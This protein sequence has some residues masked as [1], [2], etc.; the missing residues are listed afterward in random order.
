MKN[1]ERQQEKKERKRI[2]DERESRKRD[3]LNVNLGGFPTGGYSPMI[4]SH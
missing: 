3:R 2:R 4:L 1:G